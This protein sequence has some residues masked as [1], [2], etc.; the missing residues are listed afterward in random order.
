VCGY[1]TG[2]HKVRLAQRQLVLLI[3]HEQPH[4]KKLE[5]GCEFAG[6]LRPKLN[7]LGLLV[8]TSHCLSA[9]Y[10]V[11]RLVGWRCWLVLSMLLL[12]TRDFCL[13]MLQFI[14]DLLSD[15][16]LESGAFFAFW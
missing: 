6:V 10:R 3:R 13:D 12:A 9:Q 1:L 8:G 4:K 15:W 7:V 11:H 14:F 2:I 16:T 5:E